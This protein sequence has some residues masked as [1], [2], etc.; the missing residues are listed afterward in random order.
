MYISGRIGLV[1][2]YNL[3]HNRS[4]MCYCL[5][6]IRILQIPEFHRLQRQILDIDHYI[7][8]ITKINFL[9]HFNRVIA[10]YSKGKVFVSD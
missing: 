8:N 3:G 7:E 5:P 2:Q 4:G 9:F 1:G 6:S 10:I